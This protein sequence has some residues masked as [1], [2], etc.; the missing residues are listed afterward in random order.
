MLAGAGIV[1]IDSSVS[2]EC[3]WIAPVRRRAM[4]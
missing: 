2:S 4:M 1:W 3:T